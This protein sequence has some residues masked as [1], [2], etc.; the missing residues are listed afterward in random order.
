MERADPSILQPHRC[1]RLGPHR[2]RPTGNPQ[3]SDALYRA[4]L[5]RSATRAQCLWGRLRH[6]RRHRCPGLH[7]RGGPGEG[8][9]GRPRKAVHDPRPGLR[10]GQSGN[11]PGGLRPGP[12]GRDGQGH[13]Q[14]GSVQHRGS[15]ARRRRRDVRG[16]AAGE[17]SPEMEGGVRCR[18]NV[19]GYL[20]VAIDESVRIRDADANHHHHRGGKGRSLRRGVGNK[21]THQSYRVAWHDT[22]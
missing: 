2:G 3:Q 21:L 15:A 18:G 7:S 11:R 4:G 8:P 6:P 19:R 12:G 5:R 16:P 1:P 9:R 14:A 13:R 22:T 10:G 20:E 17:R